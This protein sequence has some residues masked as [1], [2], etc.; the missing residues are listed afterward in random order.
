MSSIQTDSVTATWVE[1]KDQLGRPL[2]DLRVSLIDQCNMRCRYCMPA[3][4]FGPD[5]PF[6]KQKDLL[7]FDSILHIIRAGEALGVEKV[8][9]TGGEPL[10]RRHLDTL[11]ARID[12]ETGIRDIALTTNGLLLAPRI[13]DL[14]RSGLRRVNLSLDALNPETFSQMGGGYGSPGR[15]L[16][17]LQ[18]CLDAGVGVKINC[19]V[20]RGVN[21]HQILPLLEL[22]IQQGVEVRFIEYM[23]VGASNGWK[24]SQ[25]FS[26]ADILDRVA[27]TW[28]PVNQLPSDLTAVAR[29][30]E[31]A[32]QPGYQ[33]GVIASITR[34]FCGG[35]VRARI[36]ADGKLY[37]CLFSDRGI[38][39]KPS[40]E[41]E[42]PAEAVFEAMRECWI[43]RKDRY[44]ELRDSA[45]GSSNRVEMSY[46]G[47]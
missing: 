11:I 22:G 18:S 37:T 27:S 4:I 43:G 26:E 6:L 7:S 24:R 41:A 20:R 8:R 39:L 5:Y 16:E 3:E 10:L 36:S 46:I 17:A 38:D 45:A 2:R 15:V 32:S 19:V 25:V 1:P 29:G 35:C 44:S 14:Q 9:L 33:W 13:R 47:G 31:L 40:L 12:G 28:G 21:D 42:R 30:F 23:D 34:P